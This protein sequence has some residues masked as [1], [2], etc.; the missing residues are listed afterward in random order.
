MP[1]KRVHKL[2]PTPIFEC[3]IESYKELNKDLENYIYNLEKED[4]KGVKASNEGGWH[5][6]YWQIA[7]SPEARKFVDAVSPVLYE[8]I[9]KDY[10][11]KCKP[12]H[13]TFEGMWSIINRKNSLN[14]RHFHPNCHLSAAYY[15]KAK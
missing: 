11:W 4:A 6:P 5:S 10:A 13:I 14:M 12:E 9:T 7:K 3:K 8:I 15:V 1:E 2:F